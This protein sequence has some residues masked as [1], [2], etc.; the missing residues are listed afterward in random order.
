MATNKYNPTH[1]SLTTLGKCKVMKGKKVLVLNHPE[2]LRQFLDLHSKVG[3]IISS[4]HTSK[5]PKRS[6]M[7]NNY[8][9]LYL[10]LIARS[11][12][13]NS[14][15]LHAW[16]KGRFLTTG[17][18]EVFGDNTRK[19]KST[20][21]LTI[22]EFCHYIILIEKKTGIPAPVTDPFLKA[23]THKEYDKLKREQQ[24]AYDAL[25][26]RIVIPKT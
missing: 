3:D 12:G 17:I 13:H 16:A 14:L 2:L 18:S 8:Y 7:Q 10:S 1:K 24:V 22:G 6:L 15:E 25:K 11:S 23:L 21:V 9:W 4:T 26:T 5:R 20:T 19:V